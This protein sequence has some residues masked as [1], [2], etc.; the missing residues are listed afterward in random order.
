MDARTA[1]G[2]IRTR[3]TRALKGGASFHDT[4]TYLIYSSGD[5]LVSYQIVPG[6]DMPDLPRVGLRVKLQEQ[7]RTLTWYGR[8]PHETYPDRKASGK[9]GIYTE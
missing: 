5:V 9:F 3:V 4:Y 8:G 2:T 6:A 1:K 7:F